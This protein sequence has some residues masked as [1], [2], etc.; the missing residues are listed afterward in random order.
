MSII[1]PERIHTITVLHVFNKLWAEKYVFP[2][3]IVTY[4]FVYVYIYYIL[5]IYIYIYIIVVVSTK[6][7][8]CL[9]CCSW[10]MQAFGSP[11]RI[12]HLGFPSL[13][14]PDKPPKH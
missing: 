6:R 13:T 3:L 7:L 9:E 14:N 11:F 12:Q 10:H 2:T 8:F 5:F 4:I 1:P